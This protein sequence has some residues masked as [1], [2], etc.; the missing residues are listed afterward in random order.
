[1]WT[2]PQRILPPHFK[3][4]TDKPVRVRDASCGQRR[5]IAHF[6]QPHGSTGANLT[7]SPTTPPVPT[8]AQPSQLKPKIEPDRAKANNWNLEMCGAHAA[9][10]PNLLKA[11]PPKAESPGTHPSGQTLLR[12]SSPWGP[13]WSRRQAISAVDLQ[14]FWLS[15]HESNLLTWSSV[16]GP[17]TAHLKFFIILKKLLK[18]AIIV[19][20]VDC[21][22]KDNRT[23]NFII[24]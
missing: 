7:E 20:R 17:H 12:C 19:S 4:L 24:Y 13:P 9:P 11:S 23:Y 6:P 18:N 14:M 3:G 22:R 21:R 16:A 15:L 2:G 1:M 10:K 5:H 8:L